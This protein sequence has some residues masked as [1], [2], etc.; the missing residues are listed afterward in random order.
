MHRKRT[1]CKSLPLSR[2]RGS[3]S[4]PATAAGHEDDAND[5]EVSD[6]LPWDNRPG[7]EDAGEDD[8]ALAEDGEKETQVW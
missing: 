1:A 3:Q 7:E 6:E 5:S 2:R 8:A 4:E